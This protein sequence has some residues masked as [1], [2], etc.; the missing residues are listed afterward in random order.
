MCV[1]V[2]M[3]I[4]YVKNHLFKLLSTVQGGFNDEPDLRQRM[5]N[6]N[7]RFLTLPLSPLPPSSL[8]Q[9][10]TLR[11]LHERQT[12]WLL[13]VQLS[14][15][16]GSSSWRDDSVVCNTARRASMES[17]V[18][19]L[20][21][22][23]RAKHGD[24]PSFPSGTRADLLPKAAPTAPGAGSSRARREEEEADCP[25]VDLFSMDM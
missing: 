18:E 13:N 16:R 4:G 25:C 19:E 11:T 12:F 21:Q 24:A 2:W 20:L 22:R 9:P 15:I 6:V 5:A 10:R 3:C 23:K 7:D 17:V 14:W 1:C 8:E